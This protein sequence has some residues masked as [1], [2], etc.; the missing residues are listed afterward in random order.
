VRRAHND[1]R[2]RPGLVQLGHLEEVGVGGGASGSVV[3][4]EDSNAGGWSGGWFFLEDWSG[5]CSFGVG[6]G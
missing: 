2:R 3:D 6:V 4:E 1:V 5:G